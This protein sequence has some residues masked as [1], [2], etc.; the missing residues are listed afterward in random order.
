MVLIGIPLEASDMEHLFM[1]SVCS[2]FFALS[3][4]E[5]LS[6]RALCPFFKTELFVF[7][8]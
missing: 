3:P 2:F 8:V 4:F 1:C 6:L 7:K 5:E